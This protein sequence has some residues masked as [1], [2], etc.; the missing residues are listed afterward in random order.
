[1]EVVVEQF[2]AGARDFTAQFISFAR[3]RVQV[4]MVLGSF[5]EAGFAIKQAPEKGFTATSPGARWFG[6]QRRHYTDHR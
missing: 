4:I 1:M 3:H 6:H 5:T 2:D